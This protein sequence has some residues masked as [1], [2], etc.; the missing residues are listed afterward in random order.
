MTRLPRIGPL[1]AASVLL[2]A[3]AQLI[4]LNQ[5]DSTDAAAGEGGAH[6]G[7]KGG[8]GGTAGK[9]V[10]TG[11][12]SNAT[13][14]GTAGRPGSGGTAGGLSGAGGS[15]GGKGGSDSGGVAGEA[16]AG[17]GGTGGTGG[18]SGGSGGTGGTGGTGGNAG[19][20]GMAG[21]PGCS[22][23]IEVTTHGT[24]TPYL[25]SIYTSYEYN[26]DPQIDTAASDYL[27][28]DFYVTGEY[29][30]DLT[31][32]FDLGT[33]ADEN[34]ASCSRC[35]WFGVDVGDSGYADT[36]F[37]A[38]SGTL[39]I[40][41]DSDQMAGY[42]DVHLSDVLFTEV[43]INS[44]THVS[45]EIVGGRCLHLASGD[46]VIESNVPVGWTCPDYA[47][48]TQDGCDCGCGAYD[49]DCDSTLS[50]ACEYCNDEGSCGN[51][52][53][54][55]PALNIDLT[56]NSQC[57]T[58]SQGWTCL[59]GNYGDGYLCDCGCG[60]IDYD[61][62]SANAAACDYCDDANACTAASTGT[63]ADISPADN[64]Q[65]N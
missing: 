38:K 19:D 35:V 41:S 48:G 22:E 52:Y 54:D 64:S 10:D 3:C 43:T 13:S 6:A 27:W 23:T 21:V 17:T 18:S 24:P 31:G 51:G 14:G 53:C 32:T 33:G 1:V 12:S 7:G 26:I 47:Y 45:H 37:Y 62:A 30:G 16:G 63:C 34:Y 56:D 59:V 49:P 40:A 61:C 15:T 42:P 9:A 44:D 46:L 65:C 4:G 60:I 58:G 5:F 28:V 8:G 2:G 25:E 36:Y 29:D 20:T 50:G 55:D 11:G 57:A 39:E